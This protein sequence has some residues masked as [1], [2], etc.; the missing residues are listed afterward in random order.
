[1]LRL[2]QVDL[3]E[4]ASALQDN[5]GE[6]TWFIHPETGELTS[7]MDPMLTGFDEMD[8]EEFEEKYAEYTRVDP[9]PSRVWWQDMA[10]FAEGVSNQRHRDMLEQAL[11]GRGAFRRFK[12]AVYRDDELETAWNAFRNARERLHAVTWLS[13]MMLID[14]DTHRAFMQ[15][16][17]DPMGHANVS[18]SIEITQIPADTY[19]AWDQAAA[20]ADQELEDYLRDHLIQ[21]APGR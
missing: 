2:D 10:D 9:L 16:Y 21:H 12:D 4:L 7:Y 6:I 20:D 11:S 1:M 8:E 13:D 18:P 14:E 5:N 3:S 17:R 15:E 19:A